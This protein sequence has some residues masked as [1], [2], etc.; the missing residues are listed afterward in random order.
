MLVSDFA[1]DNGWIVRA[2]VRL[3]MAAIVLAASMSAAPLYAAGSVTY[4]ATTGSD[5]NQCT[6]TQPCQTFTHGVTVAVS[7]GG[8]RILCLGPVSEST[9]SVGDRLENDIFDLECPG[10][11]LFASGGPAMVLTS[12]PM[13]AKIRDMVFM[14]D[15][16]FPLVNAMRVT[17]VGTLILEDCIF[18]GFLDLALDIEPN[19]PL[20]LVI[21]NSRISSSASG[22]LLK[23]AAGGSIN[24]TLDQVTITDNGGGGIRAD[25]SNGPVNVDISDSVISENGA[26]GLNISSGTGTHNDM[27]NITRSTIAKN[28]LV[29]IQTG[30]SNGA[31]MLDATLLDSNA[32]GATLAVGGSRILS[33]GNNRI[34]GSAGSGFNGTPG[35][36]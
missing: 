5:T 28:G 15:P 29:G 11:T 4:L 1:S 25:S 13:V 14:P 33:Y 24:A 3:C 23:P 30:G 27:V 16:S 20:N 26:N 21:K 6:F 36:Q 34:V 19:G 32:N 31:V 2:L 8:G 7:Q 12:N 17:G 35:L 10:G 22:I 9:N 18:E